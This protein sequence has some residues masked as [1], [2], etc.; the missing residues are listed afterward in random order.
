MSLKALKAIHRRFNRRFAESAIHSCVLYPKASS[1]EGNAVIHHITVDEYKPEE[2]KTTL[3]QDQN[4]LMSLYARGAVKEILE[5]A[6]MI[7]II[8]RDAPING[9]CVLFPSISITARLNNASYDYNIIIPSGLRY[10]QIHKTGI[11]LLR[12]HRRGNE[13]NERAAFIEMNEY[14]R[15]VIK[16]LRAFRNFFSAI[17]AL[18][19]V[20]VAGY[21]MKS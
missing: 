20:F 8:A 19:A 10:I 15:T 3:E 16:E 7:D 2:I 13:H 11:D 6:D 12:I 5:T 17:F 4:K 14:R 18:G 9:S 1:L 21:K